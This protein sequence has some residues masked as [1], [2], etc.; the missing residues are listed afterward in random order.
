LFQVLQ[1]DEIKFD[2]PVYIDE[3]RVLPAGYNATGP[4]KSLPRIG[5]EAINMR[6]LRNI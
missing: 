6:I 3:I 5:Y 2:Q 4:D 1:V